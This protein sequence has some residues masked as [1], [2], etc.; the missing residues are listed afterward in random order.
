MSH[1]KDKFEP[2]PIDRSPL[3]WKGNMREQIKK[4]REFLPDGHE[5]DVNDEHYK[6]F[7]RFFW[8]K[9]DAKARK[10]TSTH[11]DSHFARVINE[12]M[13]EDPTFLKYDFEFLLEQEYGLNINLVKTYCRKVAF[14]KHNMRG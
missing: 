4:F 10:A 6:E 14:Y 12:L 9:V 11:I 2:F 1:H 5:R 8:G 3:K 7:R 13:A